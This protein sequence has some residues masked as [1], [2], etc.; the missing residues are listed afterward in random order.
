MYKDSDIYK[1]LSE[2]R[3]MEYELTEAQFKYESLPARKTLN[4]GKVIVGLFSFMLTFGITVALIISISLYNSAM[5]FFCFALGIA[6][7]GFFSIKIFI[8]IIK[9]L[10][11]MLGIGKT[12]ENTGFDN[13]KQLEKELST[14]IDFLND[15]I[16]RTDKIIEK[17]RDENISKLK[18][19]NLNSKELKELKNSPHFEIDRLVDDF[20]CYALGTWGDTK[21]QLQKK[22]KQGAI[23]AE[24]ESI[25]QKISDKKNEITRLSRFKKYINAE[26]KSAKIKLYI[27]MVAIATVIVAQGILSTKENTSYYCAVIGS[28][29]CFGL[30]LYFALFY[31]KARKD[32]LLENRPEIMKVYSDKTNKLCTDDQKKIIVKDINTLKERLDYLEQIKLF[33]DYL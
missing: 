2:K 24:I 4:R 29:L 12:N 10:K 7:F 16:Q 5:V 23:D 27:F 30:L 20:L 1:Y 8:E 31:D 26:F 11:M 6:L 9:P 32:Y 14:Q 17:L 15:Q 13:F 22:D 19:Y 28:T 3:K 33:L 18:K 25:N 21:E